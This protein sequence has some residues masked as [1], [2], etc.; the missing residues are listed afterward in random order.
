MERNKTHLIT[1]ADVVTAVESIAPKALQEGWDNS[2]LMIGFLEQSVERILTCLEIN[3]DVLA[4]ADRLGA[5]MIVTHHPL[6]FGSVSSIQESDPLGKLLM[7]LIRRN[8]SVYSSHTPFDKVKGGNNDILVQRLGLGSVKNLAGEDIAS[9]QQMVKR[10]DEADIG[11][12]GQFKTAKTLREVVT[13][14]A[15]ELQMSMRQLRV[16]GDFET[17]ITK[18]GLCCGAGADLMHMAKAEGCDLFITGDV[19]YH[20]AQMARDLGICLVDA[21]HYDTEKFFAQTMKEYLEKKLGDSIVCTASEID[22][23]PFQVL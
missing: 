10:Q 17:N 19:K 1:V 13:L 2:G 7:N 22:L 9:P 18:V 15:A 23:N 21:G 16:I 4:E 11:R 6:I 8:I 14:I 5:D 3:Q 12:I 20:E